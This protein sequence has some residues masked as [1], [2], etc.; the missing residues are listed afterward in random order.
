MYKYL[1]TKYEGKNCSTSTYHT[2][3]HHV[4]NESHWPRQ[5]T[6]VE[7]LCPVLSSPL[8]LMFGN[9]VNYLVIIVNFLYIFIIFIFA[10]HNNASLAYD[11]QK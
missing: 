5:A 2:H 8:L 10:V 11:I 6:N 3:V 7:G 4:Q 1:F 9:F